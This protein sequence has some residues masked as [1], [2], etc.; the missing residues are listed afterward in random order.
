[1]GT[2]ATLN[3]SEPVDSQ[4]FVQWLYNHEGPQAFYRGFAAHVQ[5]TLLHTPLTFLLYEYSKN[6]FVPKEL[7]ES[8]A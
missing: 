1:M 2:Y 6:L 7:R 4:I 5:R 3:V 8:G